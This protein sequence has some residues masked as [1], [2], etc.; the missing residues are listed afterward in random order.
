MI[1]NEFYYNNNNIF[2][3]KISKEDCIV[4]QKVD[5]LLKVLPEIA[6][7]DYSVAYGDSITDVPILEFVDKGYIVSRNTHKEWVDKYNLEEIIWLD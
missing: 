4:K 5:R 3:G 2:R 1:T 7:Y 6:Q